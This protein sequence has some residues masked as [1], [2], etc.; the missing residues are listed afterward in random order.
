MYSI[1]QLKNSISTFRFNKYQ[2]HDHWEIDDSV[3]IVLVHQNRP[4]YR[5]QNIAGRLFNPKRSSIIRLSS[6]SSERVN[7]GY[8]DELIEDGTN[9]KI[10]L[11]SNL[12]T[13]IRT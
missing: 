12:K 3:V 13:F 5:I 1:G 7:Y 9:L 2:D 4:L 8:L 10:Q 11:L 6:Y